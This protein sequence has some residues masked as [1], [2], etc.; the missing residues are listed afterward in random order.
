MSSI[1]WK[2]INSDTI[3]GL[4]ITDLP[5]ITKA[6]RRTSSTVIDGR[7]G[8]IIDYLGY[9]PY[10]KPLTIGLKPDADIDK[11][12]SYF[13][14]EG[15]L[16]MSN[17]PN[18]VYKAQII[19]KIDYDRLLRFRKAIVNFYVQPYKF[20]Y[21]ESKI[22]LIINAETSLVVPNVGLEKSKPIITLYGEGVIEL[23]INNIAV[24]EVN[25]DDEYITIDCLEEDAY[26][27]SI[28][29]LKNR[30]MIGDF[31]IYLELGNNTISWSG[32][33]TRII[34]EPKSRWI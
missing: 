3:Q 16:V 15:D 28:N 11:V 10:V 31:P 25:I 29:N 32:N 1:N 30:K 26:K 33:L 5:P 27:D 2:N 12:I 13:N 14:G 7:D 9:E 34:I 19:D 8:D 21:N 18:K 24:F 20:L 6:K 22:D 17:E 23:Q 4:I